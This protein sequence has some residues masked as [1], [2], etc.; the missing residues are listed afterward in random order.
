MMNFVVSNISE[1]LVIHAEMILPHVA[2]ADMCLRDVAQVNMCLWHV[3]HV[4][5]CLIH[6][7][8]VDMFLRHVAYT[9]MLLQNVAH[10]EMFLWH[11]TH[12]YIGITHSSISPTLPCWSDMT[13]SHW[14]IVGVCQL[15]CYHRKFNFG[16]HVD[17]HVQSEQGTLSKRE[18]SACS[19]GKWPSSIWLRWHVRWHVTG[20]H[21]IEHVQQCLVGT[22]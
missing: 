4:D 1:R 15:A 21:V 3:A 14:N 11:V 13:V 7:A 20:V 6:V 22:F 10:A 2:H 9:D 8:H 12:C 16:Q 17:G 19:D 5:M 18:Q